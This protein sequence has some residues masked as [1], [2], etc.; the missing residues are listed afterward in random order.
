MKIL[1]F[2]RTISAL[3]LVFSA[4]VAG[5]AMLGTPSTSP[6]VTTFIFPS[7]NADNYSNNTN[8]VELVSS[9]PGS[10]DLMF[11]NNNAWAAY[12]EYRVDNAPATSTTPH[13]LLK[14]YVG[15]D[16]LYDYYY[17]APG[18]TRTETFL[19][20][21]VVDIRH[22]F[23]AEQAVH[24][25]WTSFEVTPVP[26]PAAVWLFGSGLLGLVSVARRKVA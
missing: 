20:S 19:A 16:S 5:A 15:D 21:S 3:A 25:D 23:G 4:S 1:G 18:A 2:T 9:A 17:V 13:Y 24:F 8:W 14:D 26:V 11:V 7:T 10:I 22:A 6:T 12:F